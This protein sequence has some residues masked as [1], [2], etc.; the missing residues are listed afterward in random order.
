MRLDRIGIEGDRAFQITLRF[1]VLVR[2]YQNASQ[3]YIRWHV[4]WMFFQQV[5]EDGD[6]AIVIADCVIRQG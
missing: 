5:P 3:L 1:F 2:S 6:C 4:L